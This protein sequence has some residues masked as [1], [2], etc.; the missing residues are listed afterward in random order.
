MR[1]VVTAT[2][3]EEEL[4]RLREKAEV[5]RDGW[6]ITGERTPADELARIV[7]DKEIL[8]VE[9]DEV[10]REVF[11]RCSNLKVVGC[12]RGNPVN[13]DIEAATQYGIPVINTPARNAVAVAE[14]TVAFM[15]NIARNVGQG[16]LNLKQGKWCIDNTIPFTY[17]K[18][19]ELA[20]RTLG[21][22]GFGAI[23]REIAKRIKGFAMD[24]LVY[25]PYLSAQV[26]QSYGAEQ[27]SLSEL[28]VK[29]NFVSLHCNVT[30]ETRGMI[31]KTEFELMRDDAYL[32]NT[33]RA[34][35]TDQEALI[36]A[37]KNKK[38]AG[39]AL[40]VFH[41]E[42]V[43]PGNQMIELDNVLIT[44]HIGGATHDVEKHHAR[45]VLDGIFKLL[46][47]GR[48]ENIVN[49]AVLASE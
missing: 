30:E 18:G 36:A 34:V 48:P 46:A 43:Q 27:V 2:F 31:G 32:I 39:A 10:G 8:I 26:I 22:V 24:I 25:D 5:I 20:G 21:L 13:V 7:G 29:S 45:I 9:V 28:L 47:G 44:P 17:Y 33:S 37:L 3:A 49:P 23:G 4:A 40:D 6:V 41:V 1:A 42:P 11:A 35:I 38:I 14:L 15:V 12:C 19:I 16:F